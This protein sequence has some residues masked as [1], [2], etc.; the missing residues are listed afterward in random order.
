MED[1]LILHLLLWEAGVDFIDVPKIHAEN[2][3]EVHHSRYFMKVKLRIT[4][5]LKET[6]SYSIVQSKTLDEL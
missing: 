6:F 5:S 3:S 1:N 4:L 2:P